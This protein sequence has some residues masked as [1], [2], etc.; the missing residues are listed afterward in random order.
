MLLEDSR[1]NLIAQGRRGKKKKGDGKSRFE[2]R[3]K[4]SFSTSVKEYNSI[5]M[6]SVFFDG[7]LTVNIPVKGETSNYLVRI[8]FGGFM[9]L[10]Q[11]ELSRI[12]K[13]DLRTISRALITA[14]NS[15]DVYIACS[16]ADWR[17]RGSYWATVHDITS[18]APENRPSR[19]TNPNNDI[20]PGCK[21]IMLVLSNT[22]WIL[23]CASVLNNYI[24]Y[25]EHNRQADY[26][27]YIYPALYGRPY[28]EPV[29]LSIDDSQTDELDTSTDTI[30]TA[31]ELGRVSGQ[32]KPGNPY[33]FTKS[34]KPDKNQMSIDDIIED[35]G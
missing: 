26:A 1:N 16:C 13:L 8:K 32:F 2:S 18:G 11:A 33:R 20:G 12:G 24:K 15:D 7:I 9:D 21:H 14:F 6:N 35:E 30:D 25:M 17:Y 5:D 3:V 19:I 23:K 28:E 34:G 27:K 10:L 31:N 4:S 22:R 29:Q